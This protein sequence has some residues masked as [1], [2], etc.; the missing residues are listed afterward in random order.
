MKRFLTAILGTSVML[1][2]CLV[3]P[4]YKRPMVVAPTTFRG[5]SAAEQSSFADQGWWNLYADPFLSALIREALQNNYDLK[6]AIARAK[7]AGAYLGVARAAY[8]PT[9]SLAS[10]AQRDHG[11]YKDNPDLDLPT[12]TQTRNLFLGGLSTAWEVD[13]WGRIQRSN[14]AAN[15]AYLATEE[16]RRGLMLALLTEVAQAY[17]ELVELDG[18]LAVARDSRN[19]FE[20]THTL[21]NCSGAT[22]SG[23]E[24]RHVDDGGERKSQL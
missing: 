8:S 23:E 12:D 6:T 18:R 14:E 10:G 1:S 2:G 21:C 13:V 20:S 4:D 16:G 15:A 7:E 22:P 24:R 17:L 11:V 5:Q 9:V 19:A 3:G